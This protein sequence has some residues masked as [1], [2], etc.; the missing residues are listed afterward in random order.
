M[1]GLGGSGGTALIAPALRALPIGLPK[2]LVS[3]KLR[4]TLERLPVCDVTGLNEVGLNRGM[5]LLSYFG[6]AYVWGQP[7]PPRVLPA[8]IAVP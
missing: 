2:L 3:D 4:P 6:H 7:P 5:L 8:C 1:L